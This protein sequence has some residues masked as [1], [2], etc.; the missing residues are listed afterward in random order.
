MPILKIG[1]VSQFPPNKDG[2]SDYSFYL[3]KSMDNICS[4]CIFYVIAPLLNNQSR[5]KGFSERVIL[6][7]IWKMESLNDT[8][9]SIISIIKIMIATR[10]N[11]LHIQYR[12]TRKQGG[13]AGEPFFILMFA[14]K[15]MV[16][17]VKIVLSLH[18]FWLPLEAE[19]RA[20]EITKSR[21]AAKLYK[22]YY[23]AYMRIML[24]IPDSIVSIVNVKGSPI[25]KCIKK[26]A[27]SEVVEVLHGLPDIRLKDRHD[28]VR[29][30]EMLGVN[31]KFTILLFGFIQ[32]AKGYE[33]I[34]KAVK[35]I[36][37]SKPSMKDKIRV[38][39]TGV[40]ILS[41]D[42]A[43]LNYLKGL[44]QDLGLTDITLIN[45][46]YLNNNEVN[47]FFGAA[48]IVILSYTRRVGP[49]GVFSFALAYEVPSIITCDYKYITPKANLP[50][51]VVDLN[52]DEIVSAILK[53]MTDKNEYAKQIQRIKE[54]K[55]INT[56]QKIALLHVKLYRKLCSGNIK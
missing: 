35:K 16:K 4:N 23:E 53:L 28:R 22:F 36:L 47:I 11:I 43:Y 56:N 29:Y 15:K 54:Y 42:Q 9:K 32:K 27:K 50:A 13:S 39:L 41:E 1:F 10:A 7:R 52:I 40:P 18:D 24:S 20:Y 30:K 38:M 33:Y 37:E 44:I 12:F 31:D 19:Q 48:D 45:T 3:I 51:L 8:I 2:I 46:K 25:T 49:S 26:Y 21:V 55:V 34:L 6:F 17:K 5:V 14:I